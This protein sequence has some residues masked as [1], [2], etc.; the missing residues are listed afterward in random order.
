[1]CDIQGSYVIGFW[2]VWDA[3]WNSAYDWQRWNQLLDHGIGVT[4]VNKAS[5]VYGSIG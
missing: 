1:M 3:V 2:C 4:E 5:L